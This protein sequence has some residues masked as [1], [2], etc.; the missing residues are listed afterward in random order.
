MTGATADHVTFLAQILACEPDAVS[1]DALALR[2]LPGW[3]S[4]KH[5]L[6]VVGLEERAGSELD[7]EEIAEIAT[8]GDVKDVLDRR[9]R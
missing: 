4:L 7:A 2:D 9:A 5:V 1:D 3:D 6:L 8:V